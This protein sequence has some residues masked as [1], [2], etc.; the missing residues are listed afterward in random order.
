MIIKTISQL[1][2]ETNIGNEDLFEISKQHNKAFIS[3]KIK[4]ESFKT[5]I[6]SY[7]SGQIAAEFNLY[8]S[9]TDTIPLDVRAMNSN[10]TKL[11]SNNITFYGTKTFNS[12]PKINASLE[13]KNED[14]TYVPN[15]SEVKRQINKRACFI[16]STYTVDSNPGEDVDPS[17]AIDSDQFMHWH[18]DD[19]TRDSTEWMNP[20][21]ANQKTEKHGVLCRQSG[22][23][24][25][26]GWLADNGYVLPQDCWVGLY[27]KVGIYDGVKQLNDK[28]VLLQMQP[29]TRGQNATQLQYV[30]FGLPVNEGLYLKIKTGFLVNGHVGGFQD[31]RSLTFALNQPNSFVGYIIHP[32]NN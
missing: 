30:C 10:I 8:T 15:I 13:Y 17:F 14:P 28:W 4:Y 5:N 29:W 9:D 23:L 20:E 27:G 6:N 11:S 19:N 16:D 12:I 3:K 2:E 24:T 26:Y 1:P 22:W 18:F 32:E 31:S 25:I 7:L 21:K